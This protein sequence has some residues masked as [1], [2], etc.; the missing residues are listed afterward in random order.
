MAREKEPKITDRQY[1]RLGP[2]YKDM[3]AIEAALKGRSQTEEGGSL[4]CAMLQ[5][6]TE[7][8]NEMVRYLA[9]QAGVG[10]EQMWNSLLNGDIQATESAAS[11]VVRPP[12]PQT[13]P[14]H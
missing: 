3:L 12:D 9:D 1:V 7:K 4:L 10:F 6:R 5:Q 8:R 13:P 2:Y 14:L 11:E